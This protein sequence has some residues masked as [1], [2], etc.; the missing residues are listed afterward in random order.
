MRITTSDSCIVPVAVKLPG[1]VIPLKKK[2]SAE[3]TQFDFI[4]QVRDSKGAI[5]ATVRDNITI[6][7]RDENAGKLSNASLL[8]DTGFMLSPGEFKLKMLVRE[9]QTGKMGTFESAF[10]VPDI[11]AEKTS[12]RLSSVVWS[13]QRQAAAENVGSA[14]KK[15]ARLKRHP[16]VQGGQKLIPSVTRVFHAGQ[17]IFVYAEAY[18]AQT[19]ERDGSPA[20]SAIVTLYRDGKQVL[21]SRSVVGAT[22]L[23]GRDKTVPLSLEFAPANVPPG[24]YVAQ[25]TVV[26]PLGKRFATSRASIVILPPR[27]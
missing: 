20:V 14:D 24:S 26:D 9:N 22:I 19:R 6:R 3:T 11:H 25:L 5:A 17:P 13:S 23:P 21:E 10:K 1:S 4:A 8:Y 27:A 16:L 12:L 7:L 18:D 2:G 15:A